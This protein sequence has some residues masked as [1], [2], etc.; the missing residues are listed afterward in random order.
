MGAVATA[1]IGLGIPLIDLT[2]D[3]AA[4]AQAPFYLGAVTMLRTAFLAG[5]AAVCLVAAR[6]IH[7]RDRQL[8]EFLTAMGLFSVAFV[9][10]DSFQVHESVLDETLGVPQPL[11]YVVYAMVVLVGAIRYG[12]LV[13]RLPEAGV[14]LF[15][16]PCFVF[17]ATADALSGPLFTPLLE[18]T[19]ELSGIVCLAIF[20]LGVGVSALRTAVRGEHPTQS[21][22][23]PHDSGAGWGGKHYHR[24]HDRNT[25]SPK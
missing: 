2:S 14:L 13:L 10:D 9:L 24:P 8:G 21:G 23:I 15:A 1:N 18:A 25:H 7:C 22:G 20:E 19:A 4:I 3:P 17:A 11:T 6:V 5:A 12:R 16:F